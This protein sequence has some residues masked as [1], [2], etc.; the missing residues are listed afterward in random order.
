VSGKVRELC[1]MCGEPA[2]TREHVPPY[3]FYPKSKREN[4]WTVPSCERHNLDANLDVEYVRNVIS[5]QYGTNTT[6]EEVFEVTKR[7]WE[8]SPKLFERTMKGFETALVDG[9]E[10]GAHPLELDRVKLVLSAIAHALAYRDFGREF[11]GEW[12]VHCSTL[13]SKDP[14]PKWRKFRRLVESGAYNTI[15]TPYGEVFTLG[16]HKTKPHG[17]IYRMVFYGA[18]VVYA[19]PVINKTVKGRIAR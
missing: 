19:F 14:A 13:R 9:E 8:H 7:S 1:Y 11:I 17:F 5:Y 12:R 16:I 18:F 15:E 10:T 2:M 6:A 3:C 4:I